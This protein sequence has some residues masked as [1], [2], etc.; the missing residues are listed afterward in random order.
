M[1]KSVVVY[2]IML[3]SACNHPNN[4]DTKILDFGS[5]TIQ[6][7][8]SWQ[9]IKKTGIDSYVGSIALDDRDTISFDLGWYSNKLYESDITILDSSLINSLDTNMIDVNAI[10]FVKDKH[11]TDPDKFRKNNV[12][13]DTISGY[14]AKIVYPRKSGIGTTGIYIDSLWSSGP[15]IDRFNLY[16]ENLQPENEKKVLKALRTLKFIKK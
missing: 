8:Q 11:L 14:A 10:I 6:V 9:K 1:R 4:A 13:W 3:L 2:L 12:S 16:G 7:P 5:F 15:S